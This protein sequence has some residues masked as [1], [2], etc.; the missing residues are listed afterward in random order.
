[1]N[2]HITTTAFKDLLILTIDYFQ[3]DRGFFIEPWNKRDFKKAGFDKEFVQEGHSRSKRGVLRGLHYQDMSAPMGKLVRCTV[4]SVFEVA[5]DLRIS[6]TTFGKAYTTVLSASNKKLL[7]VP[8]GFALGFFT[9]TTYA[10]MQYKQT[11]YYTPLAEGTILWNDVDIDI[12]WPLQST[13]ILS[14]RDK[15]GIS[16]KTYLLHPA[17]V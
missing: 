6:S 15:S 8:V 1:M 7:Y 11:G 10:E 5:V 13:P 14:F 12:H 16:L 17:F 3:D 2:T 4:G 9:L